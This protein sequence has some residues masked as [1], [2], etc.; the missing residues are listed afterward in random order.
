MPLMPLTPLRIFCF[1]ALLGGLSPLLPARAEAPAL[2]VFVAIPPQAYLARRIAGPHAEVAIL[3][4]QGQDPHTFEPSPSLLSALG[5]A[6]AYFRV[7]MP[8]ETRLL[9]RVQ[10][11]YPALRIVDVTAAIQRRPMSEDEGAGHD[12]EAHAGEPDPHVWMAPLLLETQAVAIAEALIA[13][14]PAH[15]EAFRRNLQELN[16]ELDALHQRIQANLVPLKGQTFY[17]FHPGFGYFADAYGLRQKAIEMEGKA[18]TPRQLSLLIKQARADGVRLI[19]VQPQFD[20]HSAES[21]AAAIGGRVEPVDPM[22]FD[23]LQSLG[24]LS[25]LLHPSTSGSPAAPDQP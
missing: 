1:C 22:A 18:P 14:D 23:I 16:A 10:A 3:V 24:T 15:T 6:R 25:R 9:E 21:V 13:L 7:G 8:F 12:H 17:V 4:R 19:L 20:R 5:R 11:V 2:A